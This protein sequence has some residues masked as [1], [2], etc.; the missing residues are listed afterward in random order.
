MEDTKSL[1]RINRAAVDVSTVVP[2]SA[3]PTEIND[4]SSN[5]L[6]MYWVILRK[7]C[8][9]IVTL[10]LLVVG[11]VMIATLKQRPVY[12]ST[13]VLQIDRESP[14]ILSF[15]GFVSEVNPY[16]N[17]YLETAYRIVQSRS[18]AAR[19]IAKLN[20]E[21]SEELVGPDTKSP[22]SG[23]WPRSSKPAKELTPEE[24]LDPKFSTAID[25]FLTR[26]SVTPIRRSQ[27]VELS[28]D[29]TD[30]ALSAR[31]ANTIASNYIEMNL[32]AKWD[33]TQKASDWLSQ[34]LVGLKAKLEKSEEELQ[35]YAKKNSI[36]FVD[37]KQSMNS[38]KLQQ[39]QAEATKAQAELIQKES[40]YNEIR[41]SDFSSIPGVFDNKLYQDLTL[42]LS[43]LRQQY[44]E[45][46]STFTPEYPRVKRLK[47]Q[48]DEVTA[49]L[50]KQRGSFARGAQDGY[51][52]AANRSRL[53]EQAVLLQTNEFNK[54]AEK[55]IQYNIL[56][57]EADTNKQLYDGLLQRLKEASVSAGMRA[58]NVRVVDQAEV[59][60]YP[61]KPRKL[62]NFALS[63]LFGLC[64]GVSMAFV[65]E[66][67]DNTL[68]SA[69][70][71]QRYVHLPT[72][73][74]IPTDNAASRKRFRYG[75]YGAS[76]KSLLSGVR[77]NDIDANLNHQ[78]ITTEANSV[79]SEAYRSLRTS[80]LLSTSGRPPR[81]IL[82][83]S[84]H[85]GEGKT[86]TALNLAVTLSQLG[87]AVLIVDS[88]MRRPR[89]H[90]LLNIPVSSTMGLS[91]FLTG[92]FTF[93]EIIMPTKI[94]DLYAI[95]SGP[96][97]PNPAELLSSSIMQGLLTEAPTKFDY[98][99]LDSPP[100]LHVA[101]ARILAARAEA[102]V[103]VTHG[104]ATARDVVK[105][106]REQLLQVN[107]NI[108]GVL[109]NNLDFNAAGYGYEYRDYYSGR[110][111]GDAA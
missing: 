67:L 34:Q 40:L 91:T 27:L 12:R 31:V 13:T 55:S 75:T 14:N 9:T 35:E 44:T 88:D 2:V 83:T 49:T 43:E 46:S 54:L 8:W 101:D 84:G 80:V 36:L 103:L 90:A 104:A 38:Q 15:Q 47:S 33:A 108:I 66:Y 110:S 21:N 76:K 57:R 109:L 58:S 23:L 78:L 32:E 79:V 96:I 62:L 60:R 50:E 7:R 25:S 106:A 3:Y 30:P 107:A 111:A 29:S 20:L 1:E 77:E 93:D 63:L 53:L 22:F 4:S 42:K 24:Q 41:M 98:V 69:D 102:T 52:A 5:S 51:R 71:V 65:Q 85:P 59:P 39:L 89:V 105:Q 56:K 11:T 28:Y 100:V 86:T 19:V 68:K 87:G 48:I 99:I 73:G 10:S 81:V 92:K 61:A 97:P 16:D 18:L 70:D 26:L 95:T 17:S 64:L 45:L 94:K 74:V 82:V 72:L 37:E 6:L